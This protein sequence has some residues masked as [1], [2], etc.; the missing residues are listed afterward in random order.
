M[1]DEISIFRDMITPFFAGVG[2]MT[3]AYGL[4]SLFF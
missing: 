3:T 4:V 2:F 1:S